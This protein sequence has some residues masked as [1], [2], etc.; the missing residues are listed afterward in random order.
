VSNKANG[1]CQRSACYVT[2]ITALD[3]QSVGS[4][5]DLPPAAPCIVPQCR[6]HP[7]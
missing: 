5:A 2:A 4:V 6:S 7:H 3:W 1:C